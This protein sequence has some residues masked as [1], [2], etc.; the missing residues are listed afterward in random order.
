MKNLI[1]SLLILF[2]IPL[3][4][5][6]DIYIVGNTSENHSKIIELINKIS[7]LNNYKT[8]RITNLSFNTEYEFKKKDAQWS[9]KLKSELEKTESKI[10]VPSISDINSAFSIIKS[11]VKKVKRILLYDNSGNFDEFNSERFKSWDNLLLSVTEQKK[12][13]VAY[14]LNFTIQKPT[15]SLTNPAESVVFDQNF[16][17]SG[18]VHVNT[19][20]I[21]KIQVKL[22]NNNWIDIDTTTH[23]ESLISVQNGINIISARCQ[24]NS[25]VWTQPV[26]IKVNYQK[27]LRITFISPKDEESVAN[28]GEGEDG[29]ANSFKI[30]F[31]SNIDPKLLNLVIE[32]SGVE[33]LNLKLSERNL[34]TSASKP[35]EFCLFLARSSNNGIDGNEIFKTDCIDP[36]LEYKLYF[37][38]NGNKSDKINVTFNSWPSEKEKVADP[39]ILPKCICDTLK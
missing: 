5:A 12:N 22:N 14:L 23:W 15:I 24:A 11:K 25:G 9:Q 39:K 2:S 17:V 27:D 28:C 20:H 8:Y 29:G 13:T 34:E 33:L 37:V 21:S 1:P 6:Q 38:F 16:L 36:L 7:L 10:V 31:S 3:A 32:E 19:G 30:K 4:P 26:S 35:N 18:E